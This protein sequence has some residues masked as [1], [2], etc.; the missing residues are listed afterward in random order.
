MA[1]ERR[2]ARGAPPGSCGVPPHQP[3]DEDREK[4]ERMAALQISQAEIAMVMGIS[5]DTI[6][7]H[8]RAEFDRGRVAQGVKLRQHAYNQAFGVLIDPDDK[9][10][11]YHPQFPP[12]EK[13][14]MFMLERQHGLFS[15]TRNEHVGDPDKP[16]QV[17]R[18]TIVDPKLD[19]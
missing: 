18:R 3:S 7:R 15:Q 12:S 10:K 11:G 19:E 6:Q 1:E 4:V 5:A 17:I 9:A 2:D 16:L 8:Y 13:M 14:T